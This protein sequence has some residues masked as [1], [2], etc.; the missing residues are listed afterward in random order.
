MQIDLHF[1]CELK[2]LFTSK[3]SPLMKHIR[4]LIIFLLIIAAGV[5]A[6]EEEVPEECQ[7][8]AVATT[9]EELAGQVREEE[10]SL[11]D[12]LSDLRALQ[13]TCAGLS[14]TS[15][16]EGMQPVLGPISLPEG[17]FRVTATTGGYMIAELEVLDGDCEARGMGGMLFLLTAGQGDDGAQELLESQGCEM[18]LT[19]GNTNEAWTLDFEKLR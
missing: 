2:I 17:L 6:Q 14:F 8:E 15:E 13:S 18:L 5:F 19:I 4:F 9:L 10:T 7:A 12:V 11:D 3:E 16:E 1:A